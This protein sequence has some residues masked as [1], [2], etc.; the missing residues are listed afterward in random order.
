MIVNR[1]VMRLPEVMQATGYKRSSIYE[2]MQK[3]KFPQAKSIG[4]RAVGWNSEEIQAWVDA[5]L[6]VS[7]I[8]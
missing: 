5:R 3:G 2:L 8:T 7:V 1:R 6:C 4:T